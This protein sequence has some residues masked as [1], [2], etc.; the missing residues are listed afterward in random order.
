MTG[1]IYNQSEAACVPLHKK[2]GMGKRILVVEPSPTLRR[3]FSVYLR[4]AGHQVV[5]FEN[6]EAAVQGLPRF[7]AEPPDVAFVALRTSVPQS[8]QVLMRL[9]VLSSEARLIMMVIREESQ[10]PGVQRIKESM[11]AILLLKPFRIRDMLALV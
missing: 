11:Q 10:H 9:R 8:V 1:H 7:Q 3:I 2:E 4:E 6:Y 5:L